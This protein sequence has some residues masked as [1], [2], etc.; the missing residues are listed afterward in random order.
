MT[1]IPVPTEADIQ[2][3]VDGRLDSARHAEVEIYLAEHPDLAAQVRAYQ[4]QNQMLHG[5]F[6]RVLDE[7]VP[8]RLTA[9][10]AGKTRRKLPRIAA[11]LA[12]V[13]L[14]GVSGFLFR[15]EMLHKVVVAE[16]FTER[17]AIAHVVYSAELLHPVEVGADQEKHLVQ[18]LSKRL[19][20]T[21]RVPDLGPFGY[22]LVGGRLLPGSNQGAAAQFMYQMKSGSRLTLYVSVKD[23]G[24]AQTAFRIEEQ[25]GQQVMYWV[26]EDLGFA[27]VGEQDRQRLLEMARVTYKTMS[28]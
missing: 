18:W 3:Y 12:W 20:H 22:Q 14:G 21:L 7:P 25:D 1:R 28:Y 6:D 10:T 24:T 26:D 8:E 13:M 9:V 23:K 17:A 11:A 15:G 19:G 2:A 27:L 16:P 4:E 5:L